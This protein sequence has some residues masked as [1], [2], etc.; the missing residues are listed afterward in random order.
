[1]LQNRTLA[2]LL[3]ILSL[4]TLH[5]QSTDWVY[6]T[7]THGSNLPTF[8]EV[9]GQ[10]AAIMAVEFSSTIT[11]AGVTYGSMGSDDILLIKVTAT[12][13]V[14][15]SKHIAAVNDVWIGSLTIDAADRIYLRFSVSGFNTT[16]M[17]DDTLL[18][19]PSDQYA[20]GLMI[21]V[22]P[23]GDVDRAHVG[24]IGDMITAVGNEIHALGTGSAGTVL[25]KWNSDL[26][27]LSS[28]TLGTLQML[29]SVIAIDPAGYIA[30]AGSELN[31]DSMEIQG[32]PVPNDPTDQNEVFVILLDL[33]GNLLW[34][35]SF[36]AM[37][38]LAERPNGIA[39]TDDGRVFVATASDTAFTFAGTS[40]PGIPTYQNRIGFLLAY[41]PNGDENYAIPSYTKALTST[42]WD[43]IIDA[44]GNTVA[45]ATTV[46]GGLVNG[47]TVPTSA[48]LYVLMK[49]DPAGNMTMLYQPIHANINPMSAFG[50]SL[51]Q[52][53]DGAY[54]LGGYGMF[55]NVNC[56]PTDIP[57]YGWR[58]YVTRVVEQDPILPQ[59]AF[60]WSANGP[61]V[62]FVNASGNAETS[63]WAFGDGVTSTD[64][65]PIHMYGASGTYDVILTTTSGICTD[66][67]MAQVSVLTTGNAEFSH[68][69]ALTVFP[70]PA[71][72]HVRIHSSVQVLSIQLVDIT[73]RP[74]NIP[75]AGTNSGDLI[76][77][78]TGVAAG[79]YTMA[80]NTITGRM[81]RPLMIE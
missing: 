24:A 44:D 14:A 48:Q 76:M 18:T 33:N 60:S 64:Q 11:V 51:G 80:I 52:S 7:S 8:T 66:T 68:A 77:D 54:Y 23:T 30:I 70:N 16:V 36:G 58:Y 38:T 39:V 53:P 10:G 62:T 55:F 13:T 9:D 42:F 28:L 40:F 32:T 69:V 37:T 4:A 21:R 12:G 56:T 71:L 79:R 63:T 78:V 81:A 46:G 1:M 26:Q 27:L 29:H 65:D 73:G 67:A 25:Q 31:L 59:A 17:A 41:S 47:M 45:T 34:V 3:C 35:R 15:W 61:E 22:S 6:Y 20:R 2:V 50:F 57:G 43:V 75:V 49:L 72:D 5:A 74:L 19:V